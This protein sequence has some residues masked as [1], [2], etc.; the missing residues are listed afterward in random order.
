M[1][2]VEHTVKG[3]GETS[4]TEPIGKWE[5][6]PTW[7]WLEGPFSNLH[8]VSPPSLPHKKKTNLDF[9]SVICTGCDQIPALVSSP[10]LAA[11]VDAAACLSVPVL[12][13][14]AVPP[15]SQL[16]PSSLRIL[17]GTSGLLSNLRLALISFFL[18]LAFHP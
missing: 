12:S 4:P 3:K 7:Q 17:A 14:P 9:S 13:V 15:A 5:I 1:I 11:E 8:L 16:L 2:I 18:Q 10:S 6:S